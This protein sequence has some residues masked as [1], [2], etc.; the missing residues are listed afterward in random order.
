MDI[1]PLDAKELVIEDG[2]YVWIDADPEDRPYR[3]WKPTDAAY[4]VARL[5]CRVMAN[6]RSASRPPSTPGASCRNV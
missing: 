1:N 5:L 6:A 2:D 3:G 4:R